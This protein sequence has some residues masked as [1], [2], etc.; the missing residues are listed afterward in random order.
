MRAFFE[1]I[2]AKLGDF[3][4][5]SLMLFCACRVA[6]LLNAFIGLY[7]V[8]SRVAPEELGAVQPLTQ[9][10]ALFALPVTV[11]ATVFAREVTILASKR[12][13]GKLKSLLRGVFWA[14][15]IILILAIALS[16]LCLPLFLEKIRIVEGSL[17]L[18][19]LASAFISATSPIYTNALQGLKHFK[20]L[21]LINIVSAPLRLI[22]LLIATPFRALTGYFVAQTAAPAFHI[23]MSILSLRR[24][25]THPAETYWTRPTLRRF[26]RLLFAVGLA[27][28]AAS[29]AGL[30]EQLTIRQ[31]LPDVESA[32]YYMTTRFAEIASYATCTLSIT[33]FPFT[34]ESAAQGRATRPL[35]LKAAIAALVISVLLALFFLFTGDSILRLL[36]HGELYA[37]YA[38]AIPLLITLAFFNAAM[39][40]HVNTEISAGRFAFLKW[41]VPCHLIYAIAL[42]YWPQ[43]TLFSTNSLNAVIGWFLAGAA[44]RFVFTCRDLI[45]QR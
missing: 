44:I 9:F 23:A 21:S 18:V 24:E 10:S 31:R 33:L 17:G 16:R 45:K 8:P 25:L 12:E 36:P 14:A 42:F 40:F 37:P 15:G 27:F 2:H 6:D 32:A 43:G 5:Y 3:W 34:A 19:I 20:T 7:L 38:S 22:T 26:A 1:R 35:V 13:F 28:T 41:F 29:F 39:T 30:I 4:W 11:F